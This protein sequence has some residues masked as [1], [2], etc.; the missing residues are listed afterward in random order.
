F[1]SGIA[2]QRIPRRINAK[3][4]VAEI[5]RHGEELFYQLK[6]QISFSGPDISLR[7]ILHNQGAVIGVAANRHELYRSLS[8]TNPKL[9]VPATSI[10]FAQYAER[11]WIVRL[12]S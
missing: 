8:F 2:A 1:E 5:T 9:F 12:G 3:I 6:G 7:Q 10:G 4:T 11:S